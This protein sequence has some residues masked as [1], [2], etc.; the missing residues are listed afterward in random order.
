[1][2]WK[3]VSERIHEEYGKQ[4]LKEILGDRLVTLGPNTRVDHQ[5]NLSAS[6]D[7][8]VRDCCAIEIESRV[9]KQV[10]G[11]LVDLLEHPL[12]KKLLILVPAH[13]NNPEA[14]A[15]H[16]EYLLTKYKQTGVTAKVVVLRGTGDD[17]QR[18]ADKKLLEA[19]LKELECV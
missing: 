7:G 5:E 8:V 1:V 11:A 15:R 16:C 6:I 12:S 10:R 2:V 9:A 18:D 17:P 14:M 13:M 3:D 4:L 19:A